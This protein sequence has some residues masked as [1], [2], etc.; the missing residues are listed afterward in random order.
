[1]NPQW[2]GTNYYADLGVEKT[3]TADEIKKAYRKL[4]LKLHPDKAGGDP[5]KFKKINE[6]YQ[7][8][9]NQQT[10]QQYDNRG[11]QP[12]IQAFFNGGGM[13]GMHQTGIPDEFIQMMFRHHPHMQPQKPP[14]ITKSVQITLEQAFTGV[15]IPVTIERVILQGNVKTTE[16]ETVYIDIPAGIDSNE[17]L[18]LQGKGNQNQNGYGDVRI[19][20]QLYPHT[21]FHRQGLNLIYRK[22]ISLREALCGF[23]FDIK[24]LNGK[25]YKIRNDVGTMVQ[26]GNVKTIPE[27][28]F[29]RGSHK[30]N[31]MI[32]FHVIYPSKI[33]PELVNELDKVLQKIDTEK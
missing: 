33:S 6:A 30:G 14:P 1:M 4:S 27:L 8:L 28:G 16:Q 31:L 10:R 21:T 32:E 19:H 22:K 7:V 18:V 5:E 24:H 29:H 13:H 2:E 20:I 11:R 26:T 3:A 12:N 15:S 25:T 23:S 17:L 9:S